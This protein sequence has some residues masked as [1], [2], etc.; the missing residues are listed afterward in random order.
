MRLSD[1]SSQQFPRDVLRRSTF[2]RH[3]YTVRCGNSRGSLSVSDDI[4]QSWVQWLQSIEYITTTAHVPA[5]LYG[6]I[7]VHEADDFSRYPRY[8]QVSAASC[9]Q[10]FSC[11]LRAVHYRHPASSRNILIVAVFGH[12]DW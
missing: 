7:C 4:L 12:I 10:Q 9:G 5:Q 2:L 3:I 6:E 11:E 1:G 8:L